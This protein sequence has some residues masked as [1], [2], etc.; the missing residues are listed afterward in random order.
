MLLAVLVAVP[1]AALDPARMLS[2]YRTRS[3]SEQLPDPNVTCLLQTR[4]GFLW[5]GTLGGLAR[6]DGVRAE[7]YSS[8]RVPAFRNDYVTVLHEG[9]DGTLWIGTV[10]GLLHR[11]GD[12][13][14]LLTVADGLSHDVVMAL[15]EDP[16]GALWVGTKGGLDRVVGARV[17]EAPE[18]AGL[19][20]TPVHDL[21]VDDGGVVWVASSRGLDCVVNGRLVPAE[22]LLGAQVRGLSGLQP[23]PEGSLWLLGGRRLLKLRAG[24]AAPLEAERVPELAVLLE[25]RQGQVFLGSADRGL[26]RVE[27]PEVVCPP[28]GS[29]LAAATGLAVLLEDREGS[30]WLG[31]AD[32]VQIS[33]TAV[34]PI[35]ASEGISGAPYGVARGADGTLWV[36]ATDGLFAWRGRA[37]ER[38]APPGDDPLMTVVLQDRSG[39]VWAG[40]AAGL[41]RLSRGRLIAAPLPGFEV[42]PMVIALAEDEAG[43]LWVGTRGRGLFQLADGAVTQSFLPSDGLTDGYIGAIAVGADGVVWAGGTAGLNRIAGRELTTFSSRDGL[44]G[45]YVTTLE[46]EPGGTIWI[47][48]TGGLSRLEGGR[49]DSWRAADGL[50]SLHVAQVLSDGRG[51]LW[52]SSLAGVYRVEREDLDAVARGKRRGLSPLLLDE[53][54]GLPS[55]RCLGTVQPA[56]CRLADGRLC[57]VTSAG[58]ALVD[59]GRPMLD[60]ARAPVLIDRLVV[61]GRAVSPA[62]SPVLVPAGGRSLEIAYTV[63]SFVRADRLR[64]RTRLEGFDNS[65]VEVG[66]RRTAYYTSLRPGRYRFRVAAGEVGGAWS[67]DEAA[68][69]ISVAARFFETWWFRLAGLAGVGA[70]VWGGV[71]VRLH[72]LEARRLELERLVAQRTREL[73]EANAE[74]ERLAREDPLTGLANRRRFFEHAEL[75]WRRAVRSGSSL[76]VALLDLDHFKLFNDVCGHPAGDRCLQAVGR[77]LAERIQRAGDLG[78]RYGGEEFIVLLCSTDL[79]G[80][81]RFAEK[82]RAAVADLHLPDAGPEGS[83]QVTVSVGIATVVP[84]EGHTLDEL[85]AAADQA[86][87]RAKADGRNRVVSV[88]LGSA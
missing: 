81:C 65:W 54:D 4:D 82:L 27:G 48:T 23:G 73:G 71:R 62:V 80:A 38:F 28:E 25:D 44:A 29:A 8:A 17:A 86:L 49:L 60:R 58:L 47:G 21:A 33:D 84:R 70:L 43:G 72:W 10:G 88:V 26:C 14:E 56:G 30:L 1:A 6:L 37:V 63:P 46:V 83:H 59:P 34:E 78:A 22:E 53:H 9:R 13:F 87:Y 40:G 3:W 11:S 15:A 7:F 77:V 52:I 32:L 12:R 50:P 16:A 2:Q 55:R 67:E 75:E 31:G 79:E 36:A 35:T 66:E 45:D 69:E 64:F 76:T 74:L 18:L 61:D 42:Q 20:G 41:M 57:F 39:T 19:R 68:V 5:V 51:T 24:K 85:I